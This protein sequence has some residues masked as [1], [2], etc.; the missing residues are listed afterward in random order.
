MKTES[1]P[2]D[3]GRENAAAMVLNELRLVDERL[4][5]VDHLPSTT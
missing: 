5:Q 2:T 4:H 3:T 1:E